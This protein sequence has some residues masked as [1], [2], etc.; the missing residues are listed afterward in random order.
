MKNSLLYVSI[1]IFVI[2]QIGI[3][4][5]G[6][7]TYKTYELTYFNGDKEKV[8]I[9]YLEGNN[10]WISKGDFLYSNSSIAIR[11]GVRSFKL[12]KIDSIK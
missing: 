3:L 12:I 8:S 1:L 10:V 11:S 5:C 4:G 9:K 2:G 7:E 6:I